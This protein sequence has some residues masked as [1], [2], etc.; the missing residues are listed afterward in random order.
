MSS[1]KSWDIDVPVLDQ[2]V[3]GGHDRRDWAQ[4]NGEASHEV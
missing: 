3:V 4:E 1:I 2:P